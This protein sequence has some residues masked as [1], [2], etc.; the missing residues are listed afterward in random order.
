MLFTYWSFLNLNWSLKCMQSASVL[1]FCSLFFPSIN[2]MHKVQSRGE[3]DSNSFFHK[4]KCKCWSNHRTKLLHIL[5]QASKTPVQIGIGIDVPCSIDFNA[6]EHYGG[7]QFYVAGLCLMIHPP[8]RVTNYP[9]SHKKQIVRLWWTEKKSLLETGA[10]CNRKGWKLKLTGLHIAMD[11]AS[12]CQVCICN[13][14]RNC[15]IF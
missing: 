14:W 3:A 8:W 4:I 6:M 2:E 11:K 13:L 1:A 15:L 7:H 9:C 5:A 12:L 10:Q